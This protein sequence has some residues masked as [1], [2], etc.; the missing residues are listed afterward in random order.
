MQDISNIK[1]R[2]EYLSE[3]LKKQN[4]A[5]YINNSPEITDIE[6]DMLY[7]ELK[8]L[9]NEYPNLKLPNSP[10]A[11]VGSDI[12]NQK[13]LNHKE[14]MYSLDNAFTINELINFVNKISKDY[15][16]K[17]PEVCLEHKI[18]GFSINLLYENGF[19]KYALTRGDGI[20]GE[21]VT[22]NIKQVSGIP[23]QIPY[24]E[25]IEIRGEI[26]LSKKDFARI[27]QERQDKNQKLFAN[28]RNAA[29][30]TIKLKDSSIV[31]ERNLQM[32]AYSLGYIDPNSSLNLKSHSDILRLLKEFS[33]SV[34]E[35][36]TTIND[37]QSMSD[38]C[39]Y[40]ENNKESLYY[41][42]DGIVL[43]I[44]DLSLQNELGY[45][46]KSPKWAI[47]Y[48]FKAEEKISTLKEVIYQVGRTGAVTP[49]AILEP[50]QIAGSTVSRATLHNADEIERLDLRLGDKVRI[51]KS[52][53]IIPKIIDVVKE[54]RPDISNQV[55][56]T[57]T[58]PSCNSTLHKENDSIVFYCD[59]IDCPA[60]L[61]RRIEHFA[62]R[63]AMNIEG[64]GESVISQLISNNL[65]N[66]IES[67]YNI[68]F[69]VFQTLDRQGKKS[70]D[71]LKY[72]IENSKNMPLDKL[73]FSLGIRFVGQK[74]SK[75]LASYFKSLDKLAQAGF[76]TL[77][78]INEIGEKIAKSITE[79]F[80]AQ[81]NQILIQNLKD[82]GLNTELDSDESISEILKDK[83]VLVTGT[84]DN[85]TRT[86]VHHLIEKHGGTL[87]SSVSKN[88]D[89][90][91]V[92]TNPGSKLEKAKKFSTI[93]ILDEK[94]FLKLIS[95]K[96][97]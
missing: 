28:P 77:V 23:M 88:L 45:T 96:T 43:K 3:Y 48:K 24:K 17:L 54:N 30:G 13:T 33:F 9:E 78:N 63:D 60:Q 73:I 6:Y 34:N 76:S 5:Y 46:G 35:N 57:K 56:F 15:N 42:I 7:N 72:A 65:I 91:I 21:I 47:A 29:A 83:K 87:T 75:I 61:N 74:T 40:W 67:I 32:F 68:D 39:N 89:Y 8:N 37:F 85:F 93:K 79:F 82:I 69:N 14:R 26:F 41:E 20:K 18:D 95:V 52:G 66:S 81:E 10:T 51:I 59:N 19:L 50:T 70:A 62:S 64:L 84:L 2:I 71:N 44:N 25:T 49:V 97:L 22:D 12:S 53:E 16:I 4:D 11:F 80:S 27:N 36:F 55:I 1:E 58:C 92:G 90:L 31:K 94:D 38:Y 86:E